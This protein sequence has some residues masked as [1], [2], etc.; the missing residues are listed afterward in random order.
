MGLI[1]IFAGHYKE[2]TSKNEDLS[3]ERIAI[4]EQ[5]PLCTEGPL[6][7]VCDSSKWLNTETN[8][9]V[10]YKLP[11][12]IRGCGCRLEAKTRNITAK[13]VAGKW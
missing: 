2:F 9:V 5:C 13:C 12:Y 10:T 3:K 11:T 8:E 6:G 4:C 1:D 7:L